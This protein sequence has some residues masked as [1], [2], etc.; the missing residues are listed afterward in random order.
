MTAQDILG[1]HWTW[2][3]WVG[4]SPRRCLAHRRS[5]RFPPEPPSLAQF[6]MRAM[7]A[8]GGSTLPLGGPEPVPDLFEANFHRDEPQ[9]LRGKRDVAAPCAAK[10][11]GLS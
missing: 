2:A 3:G 9:G 6:P 1:R 8:E 10:G 4:A 11:L 7:A 5:G